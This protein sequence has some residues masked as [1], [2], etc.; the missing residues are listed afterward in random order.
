MIPAAGLPLAICATAMAVWLGV[1]FA[2]LGLLSSIAILVAV[3]AYANYSLIILIFG[4]TWLA[5]NV[6]YFLGSRR[7][8][9]FLARNPPTPKS[10]ARAE[11]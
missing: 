2:L 10:N 8:R 5:I 9:N 1:R 4:A 6:S 11:F 3:L 7:A